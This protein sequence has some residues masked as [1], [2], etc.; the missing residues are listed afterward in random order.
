MS[1]TTRH[2]KFTLIK[3]EEKPDKAPEWAIFKH[4]MIKI[5]GV[6]GILAAL[7]VIM[8]LLNRDY[9]NTTYED[10]EIGNL[11]IFSL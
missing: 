4:R 8:A 5:L 9:Q 11:E 3:N 2:D 6:A 1:N 7:I 10:Y